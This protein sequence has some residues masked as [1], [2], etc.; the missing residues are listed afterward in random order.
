MHV[1]TIASMANQN[2]PLTGRE[3]DIADLHGQRPQRFDGPPRDELRAP[4]LRL[5]RDIYATA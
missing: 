2:V 4:A 3:P 5:Y 1:V